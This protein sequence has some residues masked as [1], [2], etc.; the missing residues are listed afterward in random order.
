MDMTKAM[1][2]RLLG[3]A[4]AALLL[5][6]AAARA[7]EARKPQ[8]YAVLIGVSTYADK[9]IK[10]RPHAEDDARALYELF[11]DKSRLGV[12]DKHGR[13]LLGKE[14]TRDKILE[15]AKWLAA[16][17][18]PDDPVFFGF[19]GDAGL[20][21]KESDRRCYLAHDSTLKGRDKDGVAAVE[22]GEALKGLKSQ[23][24]CA[25]IDLEFVGSGGNFH[26]LLET[27]LDRDTFKELL[28]D[29][30]EEHAARP[31]RVLFV[32]SNGRSSSL[33]L[34]DHS[35]YGQVLLHGLGGK[36]DVDG[37]EPDGL[38]TVDEL[39][40]Y[41]EKE[42]AAQ[43]R[44]LARTDEEKEQ[45]YFTLGSRG[46]HFALVRSP[47]AWAK[48][49]ERLDKLAG[50]AAARKIEL[51][52]AEEGKALLS[53]MPRLEAQRSLRKAYQALVDGGD[54][55]KFLTAR[56][57]VLD[58]MKMRRTDALTFA[59]KILEAEDK[60]LKLYVRELNQGEM[61][62]WAIHEMYRRLEEKTPKEVED[63]LKDAKSLGL[64]EQLQLLARVRQDLGKRE[65]LD[66]HK[67][68]DIALQGIARKMDRYSEYVTPEQVANFDRDISGKFNGIGVLV[69][70]DPKSD[71]LIVVS[72]IKDSPAYKAGMQEGDL[73]T[74]IVTEVDG[75]T[76]TRDTK[77]MSSKE[78]VKLIL[79]KEGT[80]VWLTLQREGEQRPFEVRVL[81]GEVEV[82]TVMGAR[83]K[84]DD[85]WDFMIDPDTKIGYVR[86]TQF[87]DNTFR[88][89]RQAIV[90]LVRKGMRGL[91][92]DLRFNPGGLLLSARDVTDLFIEDGVIVTVKERARGDTVYRGVA[93]GS[94]TGPPM[95]CLI[96]SSS[97]SGSEIVSA[98]L[99]DHGRALILGERSYG[100]GS[101]Q[102]IEKID[103]GKF[104]MT[105]ATFWRPSGKN[106]N[107]AS[108][109]GKEEDTWGV[110]PD[111]VVK[112]TVQ[113]EDELAEW[114]HDQELIRRPG[115]KAETKKFKDVQLDAALDYLRDK[116]KTTAKAPR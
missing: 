33:D 62:S 34:K 17:A 112:L 53:R 56:E 57:A 104:K 61:T 80:P 70:K 93:L 30:G 86:L 114:Q 15:A 69:N 16:E 20:I 89:L 91:V 103:G 9:D 73:I 87:S 92:L 84:S 82:E 25:F 58:G 10:G 14:A 81:R 65:D 19:F 39:H 85:G 26:S 4:L 88:D 83:R 11:A 77:G 41:I 107:K 27:L 75:Q 113:E 21:G 8:P 74:K 7:E 47:D 68:V 55:D 50:L 60:I 5:L 38:V 98:A 99:Q 96:N 100:K 1:G 42:M 23:R 18:G 36:S 111:K 76:V 45:I 32:K 67:D 44:A 97:A 49:Q 105:T 115:K 43:V 22:L 94:L 90:D 64:G 28:G 48:A 37:Y 78:A 40:D 29:Q 13:L 72:P 116:L 2:T 109:S 31:G 35:L 66:R 52:L 12:D 110:V 3:A 102:S 106:L 51:K 101:V 24:F 95:V 54:V 6:G 79:G 46:N 63:K 108:T 71:Q 59:S